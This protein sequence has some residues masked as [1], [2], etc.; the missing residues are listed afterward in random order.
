MKEE[1]NVIG[2]YCLCNTASINVYE[3]N[4]FMD[5]V[6]AGI[7]DQEPEKCLLDYDYGD[8]DN[9]EDLE[10]GFYFRETFIPFSEVMRVDL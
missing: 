2:S 1:R 10:L 3:I 9:L 6:L 5:Y 4:E 8:S 7:N